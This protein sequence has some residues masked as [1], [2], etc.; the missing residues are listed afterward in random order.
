MVPGLA[1]TGLAQ[2]DQSV[3]EKIAQLQQR[4]DELKEQ[5]P[6]IGY[7][8]RQE[9]FSVFPQAVEKERRKVSQ[10][11]KEM[12]DLQARA[13]K[14]EIGESEFKR[15]RDL[16]R[17]K[18]LRARIEVDLAILETMI[19]AR[20]F[21]EITTRLEELKSQ[22]KPMRETIRGLISD[23]KDYAVSPKQVSEMLNRIEQEQF[24]Q[25]DDILTN[26]AQTKITQTVQQVAQENDYDLVIESQNVITYRK[27]A[28]VIDDLTGEV[29]ERLKV[30]LRPE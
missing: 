3:E 29:R 13:Q 25:L 21:S 17:A 8:N 16:L 19:E 22:T 4:V 20:G 24:K 18:H 1:Q 23:I 10:L 7:I 28:G 11:E 27:E 9:A 5:V 15:E 14:D 6:R 30:E 12:K 2:E 26:I